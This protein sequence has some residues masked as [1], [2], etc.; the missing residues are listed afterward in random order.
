[1]THRTP[2]WKSVCVWYNDVFINL[3][4]FR[5]NVKDYWIG[6]SRNS[7]ST[8]FS[9]STG[10]TLDWE[11]WES[12]TQTASSGAKCASASVASGHQWQED[13]CNTKKSYMCQLQAT[14]TVQSKLWYFVLYH[15]PVQTAAQIQ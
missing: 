3:F 12:T 7:T 9:W 14:V 2:T 1:M 15:S 4:C 13:S 8:N 6:L 5:G 10:A 11:N